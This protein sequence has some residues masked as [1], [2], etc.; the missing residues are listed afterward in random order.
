[1]PPIF[2]GRVGNP[3][4]K[5]NSEA[6]PPYYSPWCHPMSRAAVRLDELLAAESHAVSNDRSRALVP[7]HYQSPGKGLPERQS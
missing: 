1:V 2:N 6:A 5:C 4:L 7:S 3:G